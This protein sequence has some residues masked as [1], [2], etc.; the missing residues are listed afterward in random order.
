M[1][2]SGGP[3]LRFLTVLTVLALLGIALKLAGSIL[4]Q[5]LPA[6]FNAALSSGWSALY[7]QISPAVPAIGGLIILAVLIWIFRGR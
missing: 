6:S 1:N 7:A 5:M 3:F 2:R 4:G